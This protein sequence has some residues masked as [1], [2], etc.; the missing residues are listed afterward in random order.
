MTAIRPDL[1]DFTADHIKSIKLTSYEHWIGTDN[2]NFSAEIGKAYK[3]LTPITGKNYHIK[4]NGKSYV[5]HYSIARMREEVVKKDAFAPGVAL[6]IEVVDDAKIIRETLGRYMSPQLVNH[7]MQES[8]REKL[9][10][11]SQKLHLMSA[12]I[13]DCKPIT[14]IFKI[15][16]ILTTDCN[17]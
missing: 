16:I 3:T 10:G 7:A 9:R 17:S 13:I 14:H 6:F 12:T 8:E 2:P 5:I 11:V 1:L 4:L 15:L